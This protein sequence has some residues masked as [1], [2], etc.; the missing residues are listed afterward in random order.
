MNWIA[1]LNLVC[2]RG[3][4]IRHFYYLRLGENLI[5]D[6]KS[7]QSLD[8]LTNP[9]TN[10]STKYR[11]TKNAQNMTT[12]NTQCLFARTFCGLP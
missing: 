4:Q 3:I 1:T 5:K 11:S 2:R 10:R 8:T 12:L 6:N 9:T 7:V